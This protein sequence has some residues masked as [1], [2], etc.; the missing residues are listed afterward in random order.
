MSPP[1]GG[2]PSPRRNGTRNPQLGRIARLVAVDPGE[3][4]GLDDIPENDLRILHD[5]ISESYFAE[6]RGQFARVASLSKALPGSVAGK[7]AERFLPPQLAAQVAVLLEPAKARE[8]VNT[9]SVPYLADLSLALDPARS[10]PVVQAIPADRVGEIAVELF[11]R[12]EYAAVAEFAGTVT[13]EA[14]RVALGA[15]SG[16]DLLEVVPLLVWNDNID[17]VVDDRP[18]EQIDALLDEIVSARVWDQ[19]NYVIERLGPDARARAM[20]RIAELSQDNIDAFRAAADEDK[21]GAVATAMLEQA[22]QL[23]AA[24]T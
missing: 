23:R 11:R 9:V 4:A 5:Q 6:G 2:P 10:T 24:H 22:E 20:R 12:S 14:L 21:L 18:A 1:G 7:L 8:L 3:L 17:K 19:G 13:L 15:A 16:R